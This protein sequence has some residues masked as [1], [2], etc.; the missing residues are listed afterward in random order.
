VVRLAV[1]LA[2][3]LGVLAASHGEAARSKRAQVRDSARVVKRIS[4]SDRGIEITHAAPGAE[5]A[6]RGTGRTRSVITIGDKGVSIGSVARESLNAEDER[7]DSGSGLVLEAGESG[8]VR[9]FS[10]AE[11]PAGERVDGDVVAVC[12]SASVAGEVT[13]DVV[14][15]CGSVRLMPGAS[16]GGDVVAIGGALDQA[17]GATVHGQSVSL[18][19]IPL[20]GGVPALRVL[21]GIVFVCWFLSL[22]LGWL[23]NLLFPARMLRIAA[24]ASRRA[25]ASLFLGFFSAPLVVI[26]IVLLLVTVIGIPFALLLPVVYV[27]AV[28]AGQL[29]VTYVLGCRLL[30]RRLGEGASFAPLLAGTLFVAAFFVLGTQLAGPAG[31]LRTLALF[32]GLLGALLVLGLSAIG[33]G[34]VLLSAFGSRPRDIEGAGSAAPAPVTPPAA[35][36]PGVPGP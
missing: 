4:I 1:A 25:A 35:A 5:G 29:A 28:W 23:L 27:L 13:G 7:E 11:V 18:S 34:A 36:P 22:C 26:T 8:L 9:V 21:L 3:A 19:F 31:A 15:V 12:G 10:D 2:V 17:P 20:K 14:A 16:V 30:R 33:T 32:F 24:T 6:D